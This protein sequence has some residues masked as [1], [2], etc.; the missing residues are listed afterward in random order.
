MSHSTFPATFPSYFL[1]LKKVIKFRFCTQVFFETEDPL[2]IDDVTHLTIRIEKIPK[3]SCSGRAGF[4]TG[5]IPSISH[6]LDTEGALV[7]STLHPGAVSQVMDRRIYLF[8]WDVRL[9][10]VEDSPFIRARCNAVPA[11]N[12]PIV[13]HDDDT[14]W[15]LPGGVD[16]AD[17]Y[18]G[19][20][21][22]LLTLNGK[23]DES[24]LGNDFGVI[25]MVRVF[26]IDQ[27]PSLEPEN[28]D[29]LEL[30]VMAGIIIFFHAS[31][32]ASAAANTPGKLEAVSPK[33]IRNS[34]LCA[35][36]EFPPIFLQVSL[37]QFFN[38]T[39]LF[40]LCH[41]AE[42]FL[43][44]VLSLLLGAGGEERKRKTCEGGE[45][46]ITNELSSG[47]TSILHYESFGLIG[48][49]SGFNGLNFG[50]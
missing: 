33:G 36:L 27:V 35:D 23:I 1:C 28:P 15:F 20:L 42:M 44:K 41:F 10:P 32:D 34:L 49:G 40:F 7:H 3:F 45:G 14:V 18:A 13:I 26:E 31:I 24:L 16:R 6:P 46:K 39:F 2:S 17:F 43:Q 21:L 5:W 48:G 12:T 11:S 19:R 38:D 37:F 8:L 30:R 47:V 29:P 9:C 22:T 50:S 4:H 25:V